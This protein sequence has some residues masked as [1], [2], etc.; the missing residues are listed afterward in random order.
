MEAWHPT[1]GICYSV[2]TFWYGLPGATDNIGKDEQAFARK[3]PDFSGRIMEPAPGA[4]YPDP[5]EKGL[6]PPQ[7]NGSIRQGGNQ[8]DF[9][10][11]Q[12]PEVKKPLDADG[13]NRY[14]TAGFHLFGVKR[15]DFSQM[16]MLTDSLQEMPDFVQS[17]SIGKI[18]HSFQ[19]AW[20][21]VPERKSISYI[22][23]KIEVSGKTARKG[24]LTFF[25]NNNVPPSFRLG[26]M[27]DNADS[28]DKIGKS[29]WV[30]SSAGGDS[31]EIPLAKSNRY[32]DWYFFDVV[33]SHPG[34]KITIGGNTIN[35]EAIFSVGAITFD[36]NNSI[37]R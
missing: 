35:E 24:L 32:P 6:V 12:D 36:V 27:L 14:G 7:G 9:L 30:K 33:G 4:V 1:H 10:Q 2:T 20:L 19:D 34:D 16:A 17:I 31:G 25:V 21:F 13:D 18:T 22:T 11:W 37:N 8:L 26:V 23:G 5:S 28:F 3:L 29:I 15:F